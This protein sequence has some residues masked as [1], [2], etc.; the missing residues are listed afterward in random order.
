MTDG[1]NTV[2]DQMMPVKVVFLQLLL[3]PGK[4]LRVFPGPVPHCVTAV[5]LN[6]TTN[7]PRH[8]GPIVFGVERPPT[9]G[10][11][12]INSRFFS[13]FFPLLTT[14][15]KTTPALGV[16][17]AITPLM[18]PSLNGGAVDS[19]ETSPLAD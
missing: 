18:C 19:V 15:L 17:R 16:A 13:R 7:N 4:P 1:A 11:I 2:R 3:T 12:G 14:G 6:A 10:R 5:Q 8:S 9:R